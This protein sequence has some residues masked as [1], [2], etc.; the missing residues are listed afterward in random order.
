VPRERPPADAHA[1]TIPRQW[2]LP[3]LIR[4][5]DASGVHPSTRRKGAL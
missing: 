1:G 3:L 5:L 2:R 4:A